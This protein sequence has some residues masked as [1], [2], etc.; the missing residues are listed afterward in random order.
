MISNE[1]NQIL[2]FI[3]KRAKSEA[4]LRRIWERYAGPEGCSVA[5]FYLLQGYLKDKIGHYSNE[6][7]LKFLNSLV[8]P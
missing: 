5:R 1:I 8:E 6:A 2:S 4:L 7:S 3:Q